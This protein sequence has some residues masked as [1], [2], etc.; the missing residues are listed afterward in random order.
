M[1]TLL[2]RAAALVAAVLPSLAWA[3]PL[4]FDQA[5][6]LAV[7]RSEAGRAGRAPTFSA[8][9]SARAAG[10]LP[11]PTLRAGVDNLP[12]TGADRLSTT[13]D[14]MTMKRVGISQEIGRASCRERVYKLV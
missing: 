2:L 1:P 4:S 13:R 3:Q 12:M 14:S 11:D 7:Q 8:K 6:S 9:E 5:L 10:H